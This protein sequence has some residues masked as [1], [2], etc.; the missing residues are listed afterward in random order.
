MGDAAKQ[1]ATGAGAQTPS[2]KDPSKLGRSQGK[3]QQ[4]GA[5]LTKSS[6][7]G[8]GAGGTG[9]IMSAS[10][11]ILRNVSEKIFSSRVQGDDE[12]ELLSMRNPMLGHRKQT[13]VFDVG[14]HVRTSRQHRQS[15]TLRRSI[16]AQQC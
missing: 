14:S 16:W 7:G 10:M 8:S 3:L 9:H 4:L 15:R 1:R 5:M 12:P 6:G 2:P 13:K 11:G